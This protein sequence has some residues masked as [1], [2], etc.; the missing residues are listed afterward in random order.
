LDAIRSELGSTQSENVALRQE[1]AALKRSLLSGRGV[2]DAPVL[3]P[4]AP[5]PTNSPAPAIINTTS[6]P[7]PTP[8]TQKDLGAKNKAFWGGVG[9][10][11]GGITSVHT[12]IIPELNVGLGLNKKPLMENLNPSLNVQQQDESK[13]PIT[14]KIA[15]FEGFM[16]R[17]MFTMKSLDPYVVSYLPLIHILNALY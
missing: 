14:D 6:A 3:P 12:A 1:I 9:M 11:M 13:V 8:N 10:G 7:L 5:L 16:D 15:G 4:P 17:E 2:E